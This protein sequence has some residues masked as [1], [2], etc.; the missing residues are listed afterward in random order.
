MPKKATAKTTVH[1][2][3][4]ALRPNNNVGANT[5]HLTKIEIAE[6]QLRSAIRL[7][8]SKEHPIVVETL[9]GAASGVLRGLAKHCG[10]Q[11]ILHDADLV[12]P[13]KFPREGGQG[14][15]LFVVVSFA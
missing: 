8:F 9:F 4:H 6:I 7:F 5:M 11:S 2:V 13:V 10:M 15:K 12:K 3:V 14:R 1:A